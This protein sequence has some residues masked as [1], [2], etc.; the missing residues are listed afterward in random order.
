MLAS[1][2]R[3]AF[4]ILP[5]ITLELLS[6]VVDVHLTR[7]CFRPGPGMGLDHNDVVEDSEDRYLR[8]K[9]YSMGMTRLE[10]L[11]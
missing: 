7:S 8:F 11:R 5:K 10:K 1:L 3:S 9:D 6:T 2:V 4:Y